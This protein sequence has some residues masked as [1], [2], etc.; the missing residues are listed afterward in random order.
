[1]AL[2]AYGEMYSQALDATDYE[3]G[4][5]RNAKY[6]ADRIEICRRRQ[7]LSWSHH[8]DQVYSYLLF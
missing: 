6:V 4:S 1:M 7:N 2:F 5:L 3:D 8:Q